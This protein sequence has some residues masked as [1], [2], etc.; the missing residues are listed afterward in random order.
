MANELAAPVGLMRLVALARGRLERSQSLLLGSSKISGEADSISRA[1]LP[2]RGVSAYE[3]LV[4]FSVGLCEASDHKCGNLREDA[5]ENVGARNFVLDVS[6][7][8]LAS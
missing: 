6:N 7:R 1:Q 5:R 2:S 3:K 4:W 8:L